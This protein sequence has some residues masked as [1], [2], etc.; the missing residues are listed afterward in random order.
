MIDY[1]IWPWFERFPVLKNY[2]FDVCKFPTLAGWIQ[3][4]KNLSVVQKVASSPES[5]ERFYNSYLTG[6]IDYDF[7]LE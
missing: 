4:M 5:H 7:E 6:K 2:E 3:S 1:M